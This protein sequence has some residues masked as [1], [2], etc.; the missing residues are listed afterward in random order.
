VSD[1]FDRMRHF[2]AQAVFVLGHD[3]DGQVPGTAPFFG[4]SF[5]KPL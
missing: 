1:F 4:L 2:A 3:G 5:E